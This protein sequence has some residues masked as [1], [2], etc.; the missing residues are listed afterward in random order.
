MAFPSDQII[1]ENSCSF[2]MGLSSKACSNKCRRLLRRDKWKANSRPVKCNDRDCGYVA[3]DLN[4]PICPALELPDGVDATT[5]DARTTRKQVDIGD[6]SVR[7]PAIERKDLPHCPQCKTALL[8][9]NVVWFGERLP[10]KVLNNVDAYLAEGKVDLIMVIGTSAEVY[11]AAAYISKARGLGAR[12]C[13]VNVDPADAPP[14]GWVQGDFF[15]KGDA[16][17][18]VPEILRP[19]VGDLSMSKKDKS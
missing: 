2:Y 10:T 17:V 3:E 16:A 4:D 11:P 6:P 12:V 19:I 18:I 14:N 13:V 8:R 9:P 7:I 5:H 1:P 15:F